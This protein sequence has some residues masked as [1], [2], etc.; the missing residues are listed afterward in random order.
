MDAQ[1]GKELGSEGLKLPPFPKKGVEVV[2][3][4]KVIHDQRQIEAWWIQL[5]FR[6]LL[7][8]VFL[9]KK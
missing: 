3:M 4:T 9:D 2:N 5:Y 7:S 8:N 6:Q 1:G